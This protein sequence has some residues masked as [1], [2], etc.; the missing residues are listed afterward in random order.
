VIGQGREARAGGVPAAS[1]ARQ[2]GALLEAS[3]IATSERDAE[4]LLAH[5]LGV[6]RSRLCASPWQV[7]GSAEA[8]RYLELVGRRASRIPMQ[9]LTGSQEFWSL[10]FEV[11]PAV[12]IP[13]PET[14]HLVE[15]FL[16][17]LGRPDPLVLDVG[18]GSGCLAVAVA[19]EV[20]GASVH[21]TDISD[22][23][24]RVARAN[25]SAHGVA[26]R[27]AF[28]SGDLLEPLRGLGMEGRVDFILSNPPYVREADL[29]ALE[30]EVRDYEP[31]LALDGGPDGLAVHR[32]LACQ[33]PDF[34][35][36][37]GCLVV[38][39]G[40]GQESPIRDLY[41]RIRG[42]ELVAIRPDLAGL[43]RI[44]VIRRA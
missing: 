40:L 25:A 14:E 15:A 36:S 28:H 10:G 13:R 4:L 7:V 1:L 8:E 43:P 19:C 17:L 27:V 2:G 42:L 35:K 22:E 12:L 23:A 33:A 5:V 21:A 3:G 6:E 20:P 16:D 24:L 37:T 39:F 11:T 34:L 38:E 18:T 9:H 26:G 32:R 30:P 41:G 44:A 29:A 31:R